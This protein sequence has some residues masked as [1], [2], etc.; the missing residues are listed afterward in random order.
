[1]SLPLES[2]RNAFLHWPGQTTLPGGF[3]TCRSLAPIAG[4]LVVPAAEIASDMTISVSYADIVNPE[5]GGSAAGL[6]DR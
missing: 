2:R 1:M 3:E 5:L 6:Y 4:A